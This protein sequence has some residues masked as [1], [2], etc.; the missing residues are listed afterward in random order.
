[1]AAAIAARMCARSPSATSGEKPS[2]YSSAM[3]PVESRASF[4]RSCCMSEERN[5]M[6]CRMPSM[7]NSSSA[8]ACASIAVARS[9][10]CVH[11]LRHHRIVVD[12]DFRRLRRRRCRLRTV[13]PSAMAFGRRAIGHEPPG[14]RQE[15]TRRI[16]RV[17]CGSRPPSR[18]ASRRPARSPAVRPRRRGS[19]ARRDRRR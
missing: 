7:T 3:K 16:F 12:R 11:E 6:L 5:G 17:D 13:T 18:A 10:A 9:P 15:I 8:R 19:S 1:M 14:R 4:Q 2:G